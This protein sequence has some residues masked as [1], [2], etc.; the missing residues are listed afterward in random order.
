M[1]RFGP[2]RCSFSI[3]NS[4]RF[5]D[6]LKL[7][8]GIFV[9][10]S[11]NSLIVLVIRFLPNMDSPYFD[12]VTLYRA[13][14][15]FSL[16]ERGR[17][18]FDS[19]QESHS[20]ESG[21][22]GRQGY[23]DISEVSEFAHHEHVSQHGSPEEVSA[24]FYLAENGIPDY[25]HDLFANRALSSLEDDEQF[26]LGLI[27]QIFG[28]R[29]EISQRVVG[30]LLQESN[31]NASVTAA[32]NGNSPSMLY[33]AVQ[34]GFERRGEDIAVIKVLVKLFTEYSMSPA[35]VSL[36]YNALQVLA[37]LLRKQTVYQ[38]LTHHLIELKLPPGVRDCIFRILKPVI[39]DEGTYF[40]EQIRMNNL[41]TLPL[42]I[43]CPVSW[44]VAVR[45]Y[46]DIRSRDY[47]DCSDYSNASWYLKLLSASESSILVD[48]LF[49]SILRRQFSDLPVQAALRLG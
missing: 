12:R 27:N 43:I 46:K 41:Q 11:L 17:V 2:R 22:H 35:A 16:S 30:R 38:F 8:V 32:I 36:C 45:L 10:P 28:S 19:G 47:L 40:I 33:Q 31:P 37:P 21:H 24:L 39:K 42:D 13:L 34:K 48:G 29:S 5:E 25:I 18:A 9:L 14:H 15:S 6:G 1:G 44:Y 3:K 26:K 4:I 23:Y 49:D 20:W 7:S